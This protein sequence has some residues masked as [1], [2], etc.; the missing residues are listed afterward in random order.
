MQIFWNWSSF[1][2]QINAFQRVQAD[3]VVFVWPNGPQL[4]WKNGQ[5][6]KELNH[7][8]IADK[9]GGFFCLEIHLRICFCFFMAYRSMFP[10]SLRTFCRSCP[11]S[12]GDSCP[13]PRWSRRSKWVV[14]SALGWTLSLCWEILGLF[15]KLVLW[16]LKRLPDQLWAKDTWLG[17]QPWMLFQITAMKWM[18]MNVYNSQS[19]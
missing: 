3:N 15:K 2:L 19:G 5:V 17:F 10:P 14:E 12:F 6:L 18:I 7:V 1:T 4:F 13:A 9:L 11:R 8:I 16:R